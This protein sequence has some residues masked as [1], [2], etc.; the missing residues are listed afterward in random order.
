MLESGRRV[1]VPLLA[2]LMRGLGVLLRLLVLADFMVMG[3]LVVMM[4]GGMVMGGCLQMMLA[5][6]MLGFCHGAVPPDR[7]EKTRFR[8]QLSCGEVSLGGNS[9]RGSHW[10]TAILTLDGEVGQIRDFRGQ[11]IW[12]CARV[13]RKRRI[14]ASAATA[15][16]R[17]RAARQCSRE[18]YS[19]VIPRLL[20]LEAQSRS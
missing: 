19:D 2:M 14:S 10:S 9:D 15:L 3:G 16:R 8:L 20:E 18:S 7:I 4:G 13:R 12:H 1:L 6:W 11:K 5:G 17:L